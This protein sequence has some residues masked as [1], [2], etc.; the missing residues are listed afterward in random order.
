MFHE[1]SHG[2]GKSG[3]PAPRSGGDEV[4]GDE[5]K[6]SDEEIGKDT[7]VA[8]DEGQVPNVLACPGQ[9]TKEE[10]RK[11]NCTHIPYRAWCDHCVRGRGR[12]RAAH[13][14]VSP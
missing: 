3:D 1:P 4:V 12:N 7:D 13:I 11:H 2:P 6:K 8:D 9:P 10:R 14:A 5:L